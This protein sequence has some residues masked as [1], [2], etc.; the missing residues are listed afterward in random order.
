MRNLS[1][2]REKSFVACAGTL[3]VY[4]E[5]HACGEL[6]IQGI[7]CR[8]LGTLANGEQK[9]FQIDDSQARVYVIA[10]KLSKNF[11]N[12][13]YEIPEGTDDISLSGKNHYNPFAGNPFYFHNNRNEESLQN[14]KQGKKKGLVVMAV[15]VII[16][17]LVGVPLGLGIVNK[18]KVYAPK[19]F[20][21]A[22]MTITL[23]EEF[24]EFDAGNYTV[25]YT[26]NKCAVFALE[27]AFSLFENGE[28]M[29]VREYGQLVLYNNGMNETSKLVE[30]NG[31][32]YFEYQMETYYYMACLYKAE[33]AF[34]LVQFSC[35]A[36]NISAFKDNFTQ[37]AKTI[38]CE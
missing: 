38:A 37:W 26:T 19:Q 28:S 32:L 24:K 10:D 8:K 1:I 13:F 31:L 34:W 12:E 18:D 7:P 25:G 2:L 35:D 11:A 30:E 5:D 20:N 27:E 22:G 16:G 33:D 15:S 21:K 17:L 6:E 29:T 36:D 9:T 4:I 23:T 14:R 3:K